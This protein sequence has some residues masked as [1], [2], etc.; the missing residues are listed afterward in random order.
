MDMYDLMCLC[1]VLATLAFVYVL[2]LTFA[3]ERKSQKEEKA[4]VDKMFAAMIEIAKYPRK[5]TPGSSEG[6]HTPYHW[7]EY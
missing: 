6:V 3:S 7:S 5:V 2:I 1:V 4:N